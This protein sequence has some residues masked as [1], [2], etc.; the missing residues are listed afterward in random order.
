MLQH[1]GLPVEPLYDVEDLTEGLPMIV[2]TMKQWERDWHREG[3]RL[4][5]REGRLEGRREAQMEGR[6]EG[7]MEGREEGRREGRMEGRKVGRQEGQKQLLVRQAGTKFGSA[8]AGRLEVV[9]EGVADP[10]RMEAVS[11]LVL[12]CETGHEFLAAV[13]VA[14]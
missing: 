14:S 7:Q 10:D 4:G 13:G 9:L 6:R 5:R 12:E 11:D 2:E 1:R 8:V 3:H